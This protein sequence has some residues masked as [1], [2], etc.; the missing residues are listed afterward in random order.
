MLELS[1]PISKDNIKQA[2]AYY[3]MSMGFLQKD[4]TI[5]DISF[6]TRDLGASTIP[7]KITYSIEKEVTL[8]RHG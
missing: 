5:E 4:A 2:I 6:D 3:M 7:M 8:I 1:V